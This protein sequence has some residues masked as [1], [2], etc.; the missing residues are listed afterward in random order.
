MRA[1]KD[2][3]GGLVMQEPATLLVPAALEM[4]ARQLVAAFNPNSAG[5]VQPFTLAVAVEPRLDAAS[6]AAWYLVAGN[7]SALEYG[8]LDGAQGVQTDQRDGFE[9]DGIEIKARLDFGCG[10]VS[11][12]GWV[13]STGTP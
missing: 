7:Q 2:L 12:V 3:D 11:P 1:Q 4:T 5:A 8:Y 6:A 10:W 13:K 9:V